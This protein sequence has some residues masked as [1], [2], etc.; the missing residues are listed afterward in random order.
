M[1]FKGTKRLTLSKGKNQLLDET[2][3]LVI[4]NVNDY[5][6]FTHKYD[7]LLFSKAPEL[8]EMLK[9]FTD[10]PDEDFESEFD[11]EFFEMTVLCSK[12]KEAKEL[13]KEATEL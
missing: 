1:E 13:I 10:F 8:L 9:Y 2:K 7:A 6:D 3:V 5:G 11:N 4:A 12:I